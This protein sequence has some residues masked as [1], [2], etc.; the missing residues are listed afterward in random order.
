MITINA[1]WV[2]FI[3]IFIIAIIQVITGIKNDTFSAIMGVVLGLWIIWAFVDF[4]IF[5]S[6]HITITF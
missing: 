4:I 3:V 5:L 2:V 1:L 6:H